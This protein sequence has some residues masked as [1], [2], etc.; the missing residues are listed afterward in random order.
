MPS[1][2]STAAAGRT[3]PGMQ[4]GFWLLV[5]TTLAATAFEGDALLATRTCGLRRHALR[6]PSAPTLT[7]PESSAA[8]TSPLLSSTESEPTSSALAPVW[9]TA[10]PGVRRA[11]AQREG[12]APNQHV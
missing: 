4:S 9:L 3:L 2:A 6:D 8:A 7:S 5:L 1:Y 12:L 11:N 10:A